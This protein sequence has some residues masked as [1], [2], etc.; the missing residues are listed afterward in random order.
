MLWLVTTI[1]RNVKFTLFTLHFGSEA[2]VHSCTL[3]H[4]I[5]APLPCPAPVRFRCDLLDLTRLYPVIAAMLAC[6]AHAE[7]PT[8]SW[9]HGR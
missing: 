8:P 1:A 3:G 4:V 7:Q 5:R 6:S 2:L 9:V